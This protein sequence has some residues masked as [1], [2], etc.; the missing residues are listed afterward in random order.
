MNK[1]LVI[2]LNICFSLFLA[3]LVKSL[4]NKTLLITSQPDN[5]NLPKTLFIEQP[6]ILK[7]EPAK[8]L[9]KSEP[10][11][12]PDFVLLPAPYINEAPDKNWTGPWKNACEEASIAIVEKY[13]Q[14][15][16]EVS[17]KEAKE[18]MQI[19]F[20]IQ[21]ELYGSNADADMARLIEIINKAASFKGKIK[22]N[23]TIDDIKEQI[24]NKN[25]VITPHYGYDLKNPNIPFA[26]RGS[27]YH[28]MVVVGYDDAKKEFIVHDTGDIKT[29][30][31]H[32]YNYE[33]FMNSIHDFDFKT[34]KA[35]GPAR[36]IFTR[37]P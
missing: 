11:T 10:K 9:F 3:I 26:L 7:G 18:Y 13:Y 19:L 31:N 1:N 35:T 30:A 22:E 14:G 15:K 37:L 8:D 28:M 32:R 20:K 33:L 25:L 2:F 21:D 29:G 16:K 5:S 4:F 24:R 12:I 27:Y 36:V 6:L 34:K 23:P 17:V